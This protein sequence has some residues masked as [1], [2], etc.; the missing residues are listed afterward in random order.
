MQITP[1]AQTAPTDDTVVGALGAAGT[2]AGQHTASYA[3]T[4]HGWIIGLI[5]VRTELSYQQGVHRMWSRKTRLEH[6]VPSLA[7]LGEQAILRKELYMLGDGGDTDEFIFGYQERW[8]EYRQR[9]SEVTGMFRSGIAGT[10][11]AWHLAQYFDGIGGVP[12]LLI[13]A[14]MLDNPPME[15]VL[16]AGALA[17]GQHYLADILIQRTAVRPLPTYG[18]PATLGRF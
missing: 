14:F 2:A 11:D 6:Y 4:E 18:T 9:T 1:I 10:L 7:Q 3:A 13:E 17:E 12:P 8:H 5:N 16:A 15:R